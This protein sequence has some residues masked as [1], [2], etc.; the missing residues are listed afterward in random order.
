MSAHRSAISKCKD[1]IAWVLLSID[2]RGRLASE[3]IASLIESLIDLKLSERDAV[4][5]DQSDDVK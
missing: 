1:K 4:H 5:R 2:G 3:E